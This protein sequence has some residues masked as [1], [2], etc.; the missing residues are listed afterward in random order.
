MVV[1]LISVYIADMAREDL[2]FQQRGEEVT[3]TVVG[4]WRDAAEGRKARDYNY[5]LE[6][7]DGATV[8]GPAVKETS[9]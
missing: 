6:R 2:A 1:S 4:E 7:Q 3:A 8:P 9:D 5:A